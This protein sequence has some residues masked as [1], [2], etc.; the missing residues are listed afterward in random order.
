MPQEVEYI[1]DSSKKKLVDL[2]EIWQY[3]ELFYF[4]SWRDIKVKY[5][6]TTFGVAWVLLQPLLTVA[7]FTAFFGRT[8]SL[9]DTG[10]PYPVFVLSGLLMWNTFS[11]SVNNAGTSM[12][13][14]ATII[15][16]IYFPRIIIP[17]SSILVACVDFVITF[18]VFVAMLV[19]YQVPLNIVKVITL[20][21]AGIL[22][23]LFGSLGISSLLAALNVKYR[24]FR[25]II[26]FALQIA[27]FLS[28]VIYPVSIIENSFIQYVLAL[29]PMYAA[30]TL[31]RLPMTDFPIDVTLLFIS[32]T[33]TIVI[34]VAGIF[35]FK[36]TEA[37]FADFA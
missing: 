14:N 12:I 29:N 22:V 16:K 24:D 37:Y 31:F 3:R 33:F 32:I 30:I 1:I 21:P 19:Y 11:S 2:R 13:S 7:I 23:M 35:Y 27:L 8:L 28:P 20:W 34:L 36:R 10:L 26:P 4:F 9:P 25:Y 15:K 18:L 6:Q 17:V 5:K